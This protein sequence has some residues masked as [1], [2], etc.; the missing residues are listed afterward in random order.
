MDSQ[1]ILSDLVTLQTDPY[2]KA[3]E[4]KTNHQGEVVAH[5]LPDVPEEI[6]AHMENDAVTGIE[7]VCEFIEKIKPKADGIHIMA[8]G[9]VAA[10]NNI[11]EFIRNLP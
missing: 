6:I 8:M 1:R 7:I 3:R 9:D 4:W 10:T 5:L 2:G 11:I